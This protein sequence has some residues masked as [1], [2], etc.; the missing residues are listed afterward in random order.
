[1]LNP[2]LMQWLEHNAQALDAGDG[3]PQQVLTQL[4]QAGVLRVGVSPAL[5][6][7]G[8]HVSDAVETLAAVA[9]HSWQ[10]RSYSGAKGPL[11]N[12]CCTVPT[13]H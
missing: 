10:R 8:G 7:S 6:G 11:S 13:L 9:S 3:D 2:A 1:M 12:T 4:A 5:G